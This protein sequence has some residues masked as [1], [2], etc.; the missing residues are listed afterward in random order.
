[1]NEQ[2][3]LNETADCTEVPKMSLWSKHLILLMASNC[4]VSMCMYFHNAVTTLFVT[5]I[6]GTASYAGVM[7]T[8]FTVSAT[9]MRIVSG[10]LLDKKG[11][12]RI[13]LTGLVIYAVAS[14]TM[15]TGWL[16]YLAVARILQAIGYSMATT[17]LSVAFTD[18]LPH[19]KMG[20]GLG[21]SGLTNSLSSALGPVIAMSLYDVT[22]SYESVYL[23]SAILVLISFVITF[24]CRYETD[25]EFFERKRAY[26]LYHSGEV[27]R[28]MEEAQKKAAQ[29]GKPSLINQYFEKMAIPSTI[30]SLFISIGTGAT[31]A[32]LMLYGT[33][34]NVPNTSLFF[35]MQAVTTIVAR[36]LCGKLSDKFN[37][38]VSLLPG[39]LFTG[40]GYYM[41]VAGASAHIFFYMA[42]AFI[43]FGAG[44]T[45]PALNAE[46]VKSVPENRRGAASATY[47]ISIDVGIGIGGLLWGTIVDTIGF[48]FVFYGCVVCII[49]AAILS[50]VF[51]LRSSSGARSSS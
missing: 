51:F 9:V 8:L 49:I 22:K 29:A 3:Q 45:G 4:L 31:V 6:G 43:G 16:Y 2:V 13:I 47:Y 36:L 14:A 17:G 27:L 39:L 41:L 18:V 28:R 15:M 30:V 34:L 21:Y 48:S 23:A 37:P 46:A 50:L 32:Y 40:I 25:T 1:M 10:R 20:E 35:T 33:E 44:I 11:R 5:S 7:L 12:R 38:L 42:G 26:E 24:V 19:N